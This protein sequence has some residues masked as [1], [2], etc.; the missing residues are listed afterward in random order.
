MVSG[1][2]LYT[3]TVN[4]ELEN[5]QIRARKFVASLSLRYSVFVVLGAGSYYDALYVLTPASGFVRALVFRLTL[6]DEINKQN[7]CALQ[8]ALGDVL[9]QNFH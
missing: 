3:C 2:G 5:G 4:R 9:G 6:E 8:P 1:A 7:C